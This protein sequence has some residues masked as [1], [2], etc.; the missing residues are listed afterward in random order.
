MTCKRQKC[1]FVI[2]NE[3]YNDLLIKDF[4]SMD[5]G[6]FYLKPPLPTPLKKRGHFQLPTPNFWDK[7]NYKSDECVPSNLKNIF[8]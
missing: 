1:R 5:L 4:I 3:V 6:C 7:Q 8:M 2:V